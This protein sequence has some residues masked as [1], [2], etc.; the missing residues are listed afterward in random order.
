MRVATSVAVVAAGGGFVA[1]SGSITG[2]NAG[3]LLLSAG[4]AAA[5]TDAGSR[6][7]GL[8]PKAVKL[9]GYSMISVDPLRYKSLI[10]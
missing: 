4:Q 10:R 5:S 2:G 1:S 9:L 6:L 7:L 8:D 3:S